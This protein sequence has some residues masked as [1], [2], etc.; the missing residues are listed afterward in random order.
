MP[1]IKTTVGCGSG[2]TK[3][4]RS[5]PLSRLYF[6]LGLLGLKHLSGSMRA[7]VTNEEVVETELSRLSQF[8]TTEVARDDAVLG[9][10]EVRIFG[11]FKTWFN[12]LT[13]AALSFVDW[14]FSAWDNILD[15]R[16]GK[17]SVPLCRKYLLQKGP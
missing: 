6:A 16:Y 12:S 11:W 17:V 13:R 4:E 9:D 1:R 7:T 2:T 14:R 10:V 5:I 3:Y 15:S 8:E